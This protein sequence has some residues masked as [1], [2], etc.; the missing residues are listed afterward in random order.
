MES[1]GL[2]CGM[3]EVGLVSCKPSV[4]VSGRKHSRPSKLCCSTLSVADFSCLCEF[5]EAIMPTLS[6][7]PRLFFRLPKKCRLGKKVKC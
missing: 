7:N 4:T 6:F 2:I 1:S 5:Q 3:D